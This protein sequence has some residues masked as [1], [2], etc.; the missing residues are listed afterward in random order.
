MHNTYEKLFAGKLISA[1]QWY[2]NSHSNR[3][4]QHYAINILWYL[5]RVKD[6]YVQMCNEFIKQICMYADAIRILAKGYIPI[7]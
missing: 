6:K 1:Y 4:A 5:R 3:G 2:T 7:H